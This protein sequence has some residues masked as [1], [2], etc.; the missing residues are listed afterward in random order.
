MAIEQGS[1]H[2]APLCLQRVLGCSVTRKERMKER[3]RMRERTAM[4]VCRIF[5]LTKLEE[6]LRK[7]RNDYP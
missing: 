6:G 2:R 3:E 4:L 5:L 1:V 7:M